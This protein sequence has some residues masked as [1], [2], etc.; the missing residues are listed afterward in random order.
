MQVEVRAAGCAAVMCE[1]W[2]DAAFSRSVVGGMGGGRDEWWVREL[3]ERMFPRDTRM[4][5]DGVVGLDR[6]RYKISSINRSCV[7]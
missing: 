2:C 5:T 1:R 7:Y 6:A 4:A 3:G